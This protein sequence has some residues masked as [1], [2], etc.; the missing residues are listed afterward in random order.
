VSLNLESC[1]PH[2]LYGL[3][4]TILADESNGG[5]SKKATNV[6]KIRASAETTAITLELLFIDTES[7]LS[8]FVEKA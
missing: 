6:S 3:K 8:S 2:L 4:I 7:H 5:E 1:L